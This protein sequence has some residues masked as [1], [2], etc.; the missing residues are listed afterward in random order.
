LTG[1][2]SSGSCLHDSHTWKRLMMGTSNSV[3]GK[4]SLLA[5]TKLPLRAFWK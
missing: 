1:V 5:S 3:I 4:L 2:K